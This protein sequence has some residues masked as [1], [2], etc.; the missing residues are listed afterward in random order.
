MAMKS[1][2]IMYSSLLLHMNSAINNQIMSTH[3]VHIAEKEFS[4]G[5]REQNRL[6][7]LDT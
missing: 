4:P 6:L 1:S 3:D 7:Y 2:R 5:N